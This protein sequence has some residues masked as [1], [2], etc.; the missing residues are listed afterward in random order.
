[1][2]H[3]SSGAE[4]KMSE[5]IHVLLAGGGSMAVE[6]GPDPLGA[7][8][9]KAGRAGR[10]IDEA[11]DTFE[12]ALASLVPGA[13]ALRDA[14]LAAKPTG[15]EVTFGLKLTAEAGVVIARTAGE[16]NFSVTLRWAKDAAGGA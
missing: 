16:C 9:V 11:T 7:G 2:G 4:V 10:L 13:I 15:M 3:L 14:L 12:G 6:T 8:V 5:V 1:M